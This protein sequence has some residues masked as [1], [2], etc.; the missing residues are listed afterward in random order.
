[1]IG[2]R[3]EL[4]AAFGPYEGGW[5]PGEFHQPEGLASDSQG[6][7]Y[8]ADETNHRVQKITAD[9][10]P[11]W[12]A[13][14]VGPDGKPQLGTAAGQF[15]ML[16]G[17]AVDEDDFLFVA[18]AWNHRVQKL[19]ASGTF[20]MMFG[21]Y[22]NGPGQFGGAGPN[23]IAFDQDGYI[24]VSDTHTYLGG[25]NRI[26][27]FDHLGRFVSTF[28]GYG[29]G[30]GQFAGGCPLRGRLGH[31]IHRGALSPEGPYGLAIGKSS[32]HLY[33][34]DSEN[35]RIQVLDLDG[36]LLRS[37]GEGILFG[38]RHICLDS[39]EN[40]YVAG[41]HWL[42][43]MEGIGPAEPIGPQHRFAWILDKDGN[44]LAKITAEAA[45]GLFEHSGGRHHAVAVSKADEG[46]V[47]I[48]AGHHILKFRVHW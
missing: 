11:L 42:P 38:P 22:G 2:P 45:H 14:A 19:D 10:E 32:G 43:D 15:F 33:A 18:D 39:K 9:G 48:Q 3:I 21:S 40:V 47:Y 27:K 4:L 44:L 25:N 8:V 13:S 1:M 16:R 31:E 36:A 30:P 29:T 7:L 17:V 46:L 41:F 6:N 37:I 26:Q 24:Y 35:N 28:G 34:S 23:G 5:H 12:A 20:Q